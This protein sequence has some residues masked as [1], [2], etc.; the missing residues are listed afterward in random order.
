MYL[1]D[2]VAIA[3]RQGLTVHKFTHPE[4]IDVLGVNSRI[5]LAQAHATLQ[6]R[7]NRSLM[8]A[9]VPCSAPGV[10]ALIAP[11]CQIGQ[12]TVVEGGV[13]L[14]S[15]AVVGTN[16]RIGSGCV[17]H[18]CRIGEGTAIDNSVLEHT[19]SFAAGSV[20]APL[21]AKTETERS[22]APN[23]RRKPS[24]T[25]RRPSGAFVPSLNQ[26]TLLFPGA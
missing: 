8:L 2:I 24:A 25:S 20:V 11:D 12:D 17:L 7:H 5:E 26:P 13:T 10:T 16:C 23:S 4:A 19:I 3:N 21:T 18:A 6:R 9:G 15:G 22:L 1:T 14:S